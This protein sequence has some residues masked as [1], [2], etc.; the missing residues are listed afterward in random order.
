MVDVA[1]GFGIDHGYA[2]MAIEMAGEVGEFVGEDLE[3]RR[4]DLNAADALGAEKQAGENVTA[5][6]NADDGNVGRRLHQ[7][8]AV[9]HVI[10]EV[11]ELAEITVELG[12]NRP[13]IRIDVEEALFN[14][15]LWRVR[16]TPAER[17]G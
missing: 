7:I 17:D 10:P 4:I 2:G 14:S 12:D 1:A 9:D 13:R 11:G 15:G 8:G 5:A 3:D 16:K 6:T